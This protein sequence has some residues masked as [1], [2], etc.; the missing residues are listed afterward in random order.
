MSGDPKDYAI[1]I[2]VIEARGVRGLYV[3][4]LEWPSVRPLTTAYEID[5][6]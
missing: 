3:L 1:S 2:H 4:L 5:L 6:I